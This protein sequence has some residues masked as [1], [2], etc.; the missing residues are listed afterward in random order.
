M[1]ALNCLFIIQGEGRGH[2]TQAMAVQT[3]L[4]DAGHKVGHILMGQ[5][6]RRDVPSFFSDHVTAPITYFGSPNFAVDHQS[7]SIK[8]WPTVVYNLRRSPQFMES[9]AV[10]RRVIEDMQPDVIIN[11][12]DPLAGLYH[13][14]YRPTAPM[15][16]V[17]HQYMYHHPVY[18]FP[19]G[20]TVQKLS[21]KYFTRLSSIG[22]VKK[23][24][25]S[26]YEAPDRPRLAVIPPLLRRE[27]LDARLTQ[28]PFYLIYLL[29]KGYGDAV[30]AWHR[31]NPEVKLH[32]FWDN[33]DVPEEYAYDQNL[34]FHQLSGPKFIDMMTRCKGLI[35]TA[36]FESV[37]E[38]M[39]LGK[40]VMVVPVQGHVEQYWNA[41]DLTTYGGG[42]S[43]S[44]FNIDKLLA[45]KDKPA[46][47][48]SFRSWVLQA[49]ERFVYEVEQAAAGWKRPLPV[50]A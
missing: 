17:G 4:E 10:M 12:F 2:M 8:A 6:E 40:P 27:I 34:T 31:R 1:E 26:F 23:L 33:S 16:C 29:N 32:C 21:V 48:D 5:S 13:L 44:E 49:E 45:M 22:A 43:S 28:E 41:L 15:L 42:L 47:T 9:L 7:K 3:F 38:A 11:F 35:C 14:F 50:L 46:H 20:Q 39:Y 24:G 36:G 25:I 30:I 37:C 18:P 19:P